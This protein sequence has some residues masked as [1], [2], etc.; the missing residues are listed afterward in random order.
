MNRNELMTAAQKAILENAHD[1]ASFEY[2][3]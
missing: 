3:Y 2:K 1:P